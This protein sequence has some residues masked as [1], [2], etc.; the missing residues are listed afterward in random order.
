MQ[1]DLSA[2]QAQHKRPTPRIGGAAVIA[3]FFASCVVFAPEIQTDLAMALLAGI[4][5]FGVGLR[6]DLH[7]D[8]SPMVRL[9]AAFI[10]AAMAIILSGAVLPR[11][12]I[13]YADGIL[14]FFIVGVLVTLLWS[15][16]TCHALNLIDGLN[17]LA[18]GYS[19]IATAGYFAIGGLTGNADVQLVSAILFAAIFGFFVLN[20]PYGLLFLG[21]AGAYVIGHTLAWLGIIL[22][23]R[24]PMG[25]GLAALLIL[26]WPVA[27]TAFA[28]IR[29]KLLEKD[30]DQPDR[31]HY[32]HLVVRS[33][34]LLMN[35][36]I[37]PVMLNSAATLLLLPVIAVPVLSGV[38]FWHHGT[39]A[40]VAIAVFTLLFLG[41]YV[42]SISAFQARRIVYGELPAVVQEQLN[43]FHV[44][45][46]PMS[47]LYISNSLS[48]YVTIAKEG[49]RSTWSLLISKDTDENY[50][51]YEGFV[52]DADAWRYFC[53]LQ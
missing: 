53:D 1:N 12:G 30:T 38:I 50:E 48:T 26:F 37:S 42:F 4:V 49:D 40:A 8:M 20:W 31:L 36:K 13:P 47:G 10:S 7:R 45:I 21:D 5:V 17:G 27:D 23:V 51:A 18:S 43:G 14:S 52:S 3:G 9:L 32:H 35:K 29:R 34:R 6:E 11:F 44:E 19:M 22:L 46:S 28:I 2:R 25:V 24:D 33:L 39:A 15:A 41:T 16:G